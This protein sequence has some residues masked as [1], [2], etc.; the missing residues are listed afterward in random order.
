MKISEL[1]KNLEKAQQIYGDHPLTTY[2]GFIYA[3]KITPAKDGICY[4][5]KRGEEN[6]IG[7]EFHTRWT[8]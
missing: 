3:A 7:I 6:E 8:K 5:I 4:P 1:I 2:A